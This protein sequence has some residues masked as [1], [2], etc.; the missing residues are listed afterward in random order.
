MNKKL[1]GKKKLSKRYFKGGRRVNKSKRYFK[2]GRRVNK[3]K[4]YFKG[5]CAVEAGLPFELAPA[6]AKSAKRAK[7]YTMYKHGLKIRGRQVYNLILLKIEIDKDTG[8]GISLGKGGFITKVNPGGNADLTG[9][10][11]AGMK[12]ER[13]GFSNSFSGEGGSLKLPSDIVNLPSDREMKEEDFNIFDKFINSPIKSVD[14]L[15]HVVDRPRGQWQHLQVYTYEGDEFPCAQVSK[16][17]KSKK[18]P[19]K[20]TGETRQETY[21]PGDVYKNIPDKYILDVDDDIDYGLVI[22]L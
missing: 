6:K 19:K 4:R 15:L 12:V 18:K 2:G 10:V 11:A 3:S 7:A 17:K 14:L 22:D 1:D 5:G 9:F 21:N 20:K 13:I 16:K 8:M